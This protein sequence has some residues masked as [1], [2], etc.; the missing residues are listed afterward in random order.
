MT[1]FTSGFRLIDK[2]IVSLVGGGL[3]P[4]RSSLDLD[5]SFFRIHH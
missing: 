1:S 5:V 4:E 2:V 3:N